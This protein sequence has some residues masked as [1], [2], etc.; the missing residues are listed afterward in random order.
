MS[1]SREEL[2]NLFVESFPAH[3]TNERASL[4]YVETLE[5]PSGGFAVVIRLVVWEID[6]TGTRS[7]RDIK[8]QEVWFDPRGS[9]LER[10][11]QYMKALVHVLARALTHSEMET[12]MPH[13][14]LDTSPLLLA[15]AQTDVQFVRALEQKSRLG[16]YLPTNG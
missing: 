13:D 15:K 1:V 2:H 11:Q 7:I 9:S 10:L 12:L 6:E 4:D 3:A 8:E 5:R 16:K 14:L